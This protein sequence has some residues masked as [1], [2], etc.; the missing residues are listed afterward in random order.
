M[1]CC[2]DFLI[3]INY[4]DTPKDKRD[5]G[6]G[7]NVDSDGAVRGVFWCDG[8]EVNDRHFTGEVVQPSNFKFCPYCKS[9]IKV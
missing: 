9:E 1:V 6:K 2:A 3:L 8:N 7:I 5:I 4:C